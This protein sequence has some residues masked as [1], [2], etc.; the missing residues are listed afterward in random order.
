M[1][2]AI[3]NEENPFVPVLQSTEL[4]DMNGNIL[5]GLVNNHLFMK[6]GRVY[7]PNGS[8]EDDLYS[9]QVGPRGIL[10]QDVAYMWE[11]YGDRNLFINT[12]TPAQLYAKRHPDT[13]NIEP[14]IYR[15]DFSK[16]ASGIV[17]EE[18][19]SYM[20][21]YMTTL[22][23]IKTHLIYDNYHHVNKMNEK[24]FDKIFKSYS[25]PEWKPSIVDRDLME[26][27][28]NPAKNIEILLK[29]LVLNEENGFYSYNGI[30]LICQH[31]IMLAEGRSIKE[32]LETCANT[33]YCCRYCGSE[34]VISIDDNTVELS[35]L[36]FRLIYLFIQ[37]FN[38]SLYESF[39]LTVL[40]EAVQ[41]SIEKLE[42][43]VSENYMEQ[44]DAFTAT[45]MYRLYDRLK[46]TIKFDDPSGLITSCNKAWS[47]A[48]W[49]EETVNTLMD[50][51][52]RFYSFN[53][54][55]KLLVAFK[56]AAENTESDN[57][58]V[59]LLMEGMKG[60]G[61]Y[62]QQI[63]LKDKTKLGQMV[64]LLLLS[65]NNNTQLIDLKKIF[66][67]ADKTTLSI[68]PHD[69]Q[70][71]SAITLRKFFSIW[72]NIICPV[73]NTH[74]FNKGICKHCG[75]NEKNVDEIYDKYADK[76]DTMLN[77][78]RKEVTKQET[79]YRETIIK[80]INK[81]ETKLPNIP[82]IDLIIADEQMKKLRAKLEDLIHIG[83][84]PEVPLTKENN[85]KMLNFAIKTA[86]ISSELLISELSSLIIKPNP[87][88]GK[89]ITV[90]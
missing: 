57:I 6:S 84:I 89:L 69:L 4:N 59:K 88:Y 26:A 76:I 19:K 41:K 79:G 43:E 85:V 37:T 71:K 81:Q 12:I 64:D 55:F 75:I 52:E 54:I 13:F 78:K 11:M 25:I 74:E 33:K 67:S 65:L 77:P 23:Y 3:V 27:I 82:N 44:L 10:H 80:E 22:P 68:I 87:L 40:S 5:H 83:P 60:K 20:S 15:L 32:V 16:I 42:L 58:A 66:K 56:A 18:Y 86:K 73:N 31:E 53:H 8:N 90:M 70:M 47:R 1:I 24:E 14:D 38:I 61:N 28:K 62:I 63:Y 34:L 36:Q 46:G 35:A 2:S 51:D 50:S 30:P 49:D 9:F 29:K 39:L 72:W 7:S 17:D 21:Q 48:G 45:Y